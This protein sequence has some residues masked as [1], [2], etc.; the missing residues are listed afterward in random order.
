MTAD[1]EP[2]APLQH[3]PAA[4]RREPEPAEPQREPEPAVPR[5]EPRPKQAS[6]PRLPRDAYAGIVSRVLA[7]AVDAVLIAIVAPAI[8]A[9]G[10]ALWGAI[11]G[12]APDWLRVCAG[13]IAGLV[14][15][16]YFWLCW[17]TTGRTLGGALVGTAVRRPDGTRLSTLRAAERA[18]IGLLF[19]PFWLAGLL[20]SVL[21]PRRRAL[22]DVLLHTVVLRVGG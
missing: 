8:G 10:P 7:L 6:V 1:D 21:D 14:P 22:H 4:P 16:A 9:G 17:C 2:A 13:I 20:F 11:V 18:F 3:R 5:P 15:F 19:A 12:T